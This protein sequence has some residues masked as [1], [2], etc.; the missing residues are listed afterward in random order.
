[1]KILLVIVASFFSSVITAQYDVVAFQD[2]YTE[3]EGYHSIAL[4]TFGNRAWVK[5]FELPFN[6]PYF[7]YDFDY[8][9][10][11]VEGTCYFEDDLDFSLRLMTFG[12]KYD[13]ILDTVNIESDVRYKFGEKDGKSYLAVQLTKNRLF[14]DPSVDEFDSYVNFQYWIFDDGTIE[15][16]FGP[17]NLDHSP[18][19]VPG[20]GFYLLTNEGPKPA[21][22]QLALY[23]PYDENIRLEYNDLNNYTEYE[24]TTVELGGINWWPP[25]GW[26]IR[27]TNKRVSTNELASN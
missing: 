2:N 11:E 1:M 8:L 24:L 23:H 7:D 15:L 14:S 5:K 25:D 27:F 26:V 17:S 22:P 9:I 6:F 4:E 19:Y 20:E 12:Y 21:G 18:V 16:R 3:I 13:E 10:C